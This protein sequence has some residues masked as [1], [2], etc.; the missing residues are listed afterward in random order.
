MRGGGGREEGG[1]ERGER[2]GLESFP[3]PYP[4]LSLHRQVAGLPDVQIWGKL[5]YVDN[6]AATQR[7]NWHVHRQQ[8]CLKAWL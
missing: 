2:G 7:H 3:S 1:G 4:T 5:Y 8:V 6:S